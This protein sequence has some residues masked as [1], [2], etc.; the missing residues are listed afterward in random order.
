MAVARPIITAERGAYD[1]LARETG[2]LFDLPEWS[3][4]F[5]ERLVRCGIFSKSGELIGGFQYLRM[6]KMGLSV[7]RNPPFTPHCG[8]F[9]RIGATRPVTILEEKR[10]ALEAMAKYLSGL[11]TGVVFLSL[12]PSIQ[13]GLPFLWKQF[14]VSP[15]YTYIIDLCLSP[16]E[17]LASYASRIRGHISKAKKDGLEARI[18]L[19]PQVIREIQSR[20]LQRN[21]KRFDERAMDDILSQFA[22]HSR[23]FTV[24]I[25][26]DGKPLA[27]VLV[28]HAGGYGY[29]LMG[30]YRK[31]DSHPGAGTLAFHEAILRAK[32]I[33]L[34]MFDFEGSRLPAIEYVF[35]GF[36][37]RLVHGFQL[38]RGWLPVE[39]ALKLRWREYF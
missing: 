17:I 30:G 3:D 29:Y 6:R 7:V 37:G 11:N 32:E 19:E 16:E 25:Y 4:L 35:R 31:A 18:G 10:S 36:G 33:G 26:K 5:G 22:T 13:D 14:K 38:A 23:A 9:L 39:M 15:A 21:D 27:A 12:S 28:L 8:P 24:C 1:T 20:A 2:T 34:R